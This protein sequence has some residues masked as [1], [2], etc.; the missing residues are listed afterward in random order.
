MNRELRQSKSACAIKGRRETIRP[1]SPRMACVSTVTGRL[2]EEKIQNGEEGRSHQR[3]RWRGSLPLVCN[4]QSI[5][6]NRF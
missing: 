4:R 3:I 5:L 2:V 6:S 1:Q